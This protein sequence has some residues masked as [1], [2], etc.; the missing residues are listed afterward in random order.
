MP[1]LSVL[2]KMYGSDTPVLACAA[3]T[4]PTCG[5]ARGAVPARA[6]GHP[7]PKR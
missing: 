5:D 3:R 6:H 4:V 1:S 7:D 2:I